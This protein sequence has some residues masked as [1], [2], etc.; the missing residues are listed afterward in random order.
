MK[1]ALTCSAAVLALSV[2]IAGCM[3]APEA[4]SGW[5]TQFDKAKALAAE[6]KAPILAD[7]SGS[8]WCGWCMRLDAEVFSTDEFKAYAGKNLVLF[9]ADFPRGKQQPEEIVEQNR[10]LAEKYGIRGLPTLLLL[11]AE[12]RE[13]ARTGY[14]PGGGA[15]Y[16]EHLKSL[17]KEAEAGG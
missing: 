3:A 2:G 17:L 8:D 9:V 16:V 13:L 11:D 15:A 14:R 6:K 12:G 1:K 7:F 4:K 10:K 5:M